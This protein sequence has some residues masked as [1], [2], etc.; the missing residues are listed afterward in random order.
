MPLDFV[1]NIVNSKAVQGPD[2]AKNAGSLMLGAVEVNLNSLADLANI[3]ITVRGDPYWLGQPKGQSGGA[4][5][6]R[7]G[8]N[9]FLNI[10]FPTYPD[11]STGLMNIVE[12]DFGITGLYRVT[13]VQ[14]RYADGQFIMMLDAFRDTNTNVGL[15]LEELTSGEISLDNFRQLADVYT[16]PEQGDGPGD[17]NVTPS[18][19][20]P[21]NINF[22]N[23]TGTGTVTQSQSGIRNQPITS[24]LESIL[25][26]AGANAGVNVVVTSGGQPSS[27]PNRTGSTRHDNGRAA[28]VQLFVLGRNTPLS[29]NNAADVPIIQNFINQSRLAGATG[30]G[31]GNGYMGDNTFHID[32]AQP[33]SVQYWGG[34]LDNGTFRARNAPSWLRDIARGLV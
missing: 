4:P 24:S 29:L 14:A 18:S 21:G 12:R 6:T 5:Y 25:Q 28:D 8:N 27:G 15:V 16:S 17:G 23:G 32:N 22:V 20:G 11:D 1:P 7:G 3:M 9:F 33:G 30:L 19:T 10:N 26:R 13:Q 2:K 31:A 34:Q